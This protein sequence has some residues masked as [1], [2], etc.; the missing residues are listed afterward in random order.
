MSTTLKEQLKNISLEL[1]A[2]GMRTAYHIVQKALQEIL[3]LEEKHDNLVLINEV[4]RLRAEVVCLEDIKQAYETFEGSVG[5]S[6]HKT[7]DSR[8][9]DAF[10]CLEEDLAEATTEGAL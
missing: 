5:D 3:H 9:E 1:R 4:V 2:D 10:E 8:L 6:L 7:T